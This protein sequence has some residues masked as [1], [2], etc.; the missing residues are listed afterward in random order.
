VPLFRVP[1]QII[2]RRGLLDPQ[3]AA[4]AGALRTVGF[5]EVHDVHVGRFVVVQTEAADAAAASDAVKRMCEK[6]LANPVT[7]DFTLEP[8]VEETPVA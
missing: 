5:P 2:P 3:G 8:A 6:L 7:E 1:V 4:V